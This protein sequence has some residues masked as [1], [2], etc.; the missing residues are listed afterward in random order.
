MIIIIP[1]ILSFC[2]VRGGMYRRKLP[3]EKLP[4]YNAILKHPKLCEMNFVKWNYVA[5]Y[6]GNVMLRERCVTNIFHYLR[7]LFYF[8]NCAPWKNWDKR[9][10]CNDIAVSVCHEILSGAIAHNRALSSCF[11]RF[12]NYWAALPYFLVSTL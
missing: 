2:D 6:V 10:S 1:K 9:Q 7:E 12:W 8:F 3:W 5:I 11:L 4:V